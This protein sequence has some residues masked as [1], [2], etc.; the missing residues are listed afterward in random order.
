MR[1]DEDKNTT[2][3]LSFVSDRIAESICLVE[4]RFK[5]ILTKVSCCQSLGDLDKIEQ[6]PLRFY[7]QFRS[8]LSFSELGRQISKRCSNCRRRG[9]TGERKGDAVRSVVEPWILGTRLAGVRV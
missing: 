4:N 7:T 1:S 5:N 9:I 8:K 2:Q 3:I 6:H